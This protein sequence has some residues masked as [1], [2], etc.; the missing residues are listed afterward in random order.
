MSNEKAQ[1]TTI[2]IGPCRF[3]YLNALVAKSI[4]QADGS[5]SA[6]KYSV[7]LLIPKSDKALLAKVQ[8]AHDAAF[9]LGVEQKK[10]PAKKSKAFKDA[11]HDGDEKML[12]DNVTPDP[13]Y[14]GHWYVNASSTDKP[15][16]VDAK[17]V[18]MMN[19]SEEEVYSGMTGR[20]HVNFFPYN[21]LSQGI[22]CGL[23]HL[24]KLRDGEKLGG[25]PALESAFNDDFVFTDD[26]SDLD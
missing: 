14:A 3:S 4:T 2:I 25:K 16:W 9:A 6:P 26:N 21:K 23:N 18:A 8:A 5:S 7:S 12:K 10:F 19:P 20:A 15:G 11:I 13:V 1:H 24:Q 17:G 22:G